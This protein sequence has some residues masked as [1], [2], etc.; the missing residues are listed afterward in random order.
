RRW[1]N[2]ADPHG[3]RARAGRSEFLPQ[4]RK[5]WLLAIGQRLRAEYA[6]V[7]D[8]I[9]ERLAALVAR[10]EEPAPAASDGAAAGQAS[11]PGQAPSQ[12]VPP[13]SPA[14]ESDRS[15]SEYPRS[16]VRDAAGAPPGLELR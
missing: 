10:L 12:S 15:V 16:S 1:D 14:P 13:R 4:D 9:P 5:E 2:R 7:G 8:P 6:A 11:S 3:R